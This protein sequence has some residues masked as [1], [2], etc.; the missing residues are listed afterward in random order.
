[1]RAKKTRENRG[2]IAGQRE[3]EERYS[4]RARE[5]QID[6][7]NVDNKAER[8]TAGEQVLLRYVKGWERFVT[9]LDLGPTL[10]AFF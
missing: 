6:R 1:M 3:K 2:T 9:A 8:A 7:G 5:V 10:N 4:N